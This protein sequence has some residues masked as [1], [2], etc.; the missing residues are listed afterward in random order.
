MFDA[1]PLQIGFVLPQS[2]DGFISFH[3]Q[4]VANP[5]GWFYGFRL[6]RSPLGAVPDSTQAIIRYRHVTRSAAR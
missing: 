3:R 5:N 6:R 1:K 4:I 2:A